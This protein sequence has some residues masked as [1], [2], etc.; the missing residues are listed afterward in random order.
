M[1]LRTGGVKAS[2]VLSGR[3][4][5][6]IKSADG[7]NIGLLLNRISGRFW[8]EYMAVL[9]TTAIAPRRRDVERIA[10]Q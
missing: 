7:P 5:Y 3:C 1:G 10:A 4:H 2:L 8:I 6:R 9:E